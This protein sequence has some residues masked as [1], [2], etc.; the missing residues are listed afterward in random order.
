MRQHRVVLALGAT[1]LVGLLAGCSAGSSNSSD[2]AGSG[3]PNA[4]VPNAAGGQAAPSGGAAG[5]SG[6]SGNSG[7]AGA[8]SPSASSGRQVI[9]SA[10]V[11]MTA[12]NVTDTVDGVDQVAI[13]AGGYLS[14]EDLQADFASVTLSVPEAKLDSVLGQ[15]AKLGTVTDQQQQ[16][17]D[18]TDQ[19]V[20]V[21]SRIATQ[22]ASVDRVRQLLAQ[23]TSISDIVQIEGELT[24]RESDLESMEHQQAELTGQVAMS[25]VSMKISR[26]TPPVVAQAAGPAPGFTNGLSGGWHA[27]GATV[28]VLLLVL[29]SA[30]PFLLGIGIPVLAVLWALRVLRRRRRGGPVGPPVDPMAG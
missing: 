17:Q 13:N 18:V 26:T 24:T 20:D 9:R 29:G 15:L 1:M 2:A 23:A 4:A 6:S 11:S 14:A 21:S 25:S 7:T 22:Q 30:L 8:S 28:R 27:L 12:R 3:V 10:D 19:L 5:G 16:S